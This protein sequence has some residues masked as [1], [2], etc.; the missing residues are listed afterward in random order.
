MVSAAAP[1]AIEPLAS[2]EVLKKRRIGVGAPVLLHSARAAQPFGWAYSAHLAEQLLWPRSRREI[3][4]HT[5]AG[6]RRR[7]LM[8]LLCLTR[9]SNGMFNFTACQASEAMGLS[10]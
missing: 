2:S 8:F 5:E 6:E 3:R 10:S 7:E 1:H 4:P 9:H